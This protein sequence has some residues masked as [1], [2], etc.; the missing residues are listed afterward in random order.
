MGFLEQPVG[1]CR[2]RMENVVGVGFVPVA[3]PPPRELVVRAADRAQ[4][5]SDRCHHR[6]KCVFAQ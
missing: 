1:A 2:I 5:R 3:E 4:G 6:L